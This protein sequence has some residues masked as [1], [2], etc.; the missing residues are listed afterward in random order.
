MRWQNASLWRTFR[1][2]C[3]CIAVNSVGRAVVGC[4]K[5][6]CIYA[7]AFC[8]ALG[9]KVFED[10]RDRLFNP[11][12]GSFLFQWTYTLDLSVGTFSS[13]FLQIYLVAAVDEVALTL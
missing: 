1:V 3:C 8:L 2:S 7:T 6:I 12:N 10:Y 13:C 4:Q 9:D 5:L 11:V